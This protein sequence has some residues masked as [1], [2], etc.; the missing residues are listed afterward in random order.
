MCEAPVLLR[1]TLPALPPER[2][3]SAVRRRR[4][5]CRVHA[6]DLRVPSPGS[7]LCHQPV[8]CPEAGRIDVRPVRV[9]LTSARRHLS[10]RAGS[11]A[12]RTLPGRAH[13]TGSGVLS[14][15]PSDAVFTG[16]PT[17]GRDSTRRCL[18]VRSPFTGIATFTSPRPE[19]WWKPRRQR[20]P[21]DRLCTTSWNV[22]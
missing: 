13:T 16:S 8:P 1:N 10:V 20:I 17:R 2:E 18:T 22:K 6:V 5:G 4:P 19:A 9:F 7:L 15:H 11:S 12:G 14:C 3:S 21:V